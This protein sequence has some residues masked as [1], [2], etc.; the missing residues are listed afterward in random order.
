MEIVARFGKSRI[1]LQRKS[2]MDPKKKQQLEA[3][4]WVATSVQDFLALPTP[5][6]AY[7]ETKL[8]LSQTVKDLRRK[9]KLTQTA[10]AELLNSSQSR[11]A[12]MEKADNSVSIDLLL[13]AAYTLGATTD[14]VAVALREPRAD[15]IVGDSSEEKV[16]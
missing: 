14:D 13:K 11:I 9:K 2:I 15:Y 10:V 12:K 5:E 6:M 8:K 16:D 7:I 1:D 4:G 3:N